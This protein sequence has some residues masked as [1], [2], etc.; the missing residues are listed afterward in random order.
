MRI[1]RLKLV[2]FI[3]IKNGLGKNEI[4]I[5]F[6]NNGNII[7]SLSGKNGS[8]KSTIMSMLSPFKESFDDRKTL[9]LPGKEGIK[10]IDYIHN[11]HEYKIKH[12]YSAKAASFISEDGVEL[13]ENGGI[14]TFEEI[15]KTKFK[16]SKDYFK[17]GKV[18]SNTENFIQFTT[19]QRKTYIS[20]FVEA[21]QKYI[22][23]FKIVS[24]KAK[25][26][27]QQIKQISS[28]LKQLDDISTVLHKIEENETTL[29]ELENSISVLTT[30]IA[31][32]DSDINILSKTMSDINYIETKTLLKTK[33]DS[34]RKNYV[35][36]EKFDKIYN[37]VDI[38]NCD[39]YISEIK[40]ELNK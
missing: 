3:G 2:N 25:V 32:L 24:E 12:I 29:K 26:N 30:D 34:L 20:S 6:P 27:E 16:L 11:G 18:G 33:E 39:Q 8:G 19:A 14:R 5:T 9:I 37:N 31:R 38:S 13:N 35:I 4:E 40:D 23:A 21:V 10:E 7:T 28:D 22:D 17:I 36:N 15:I 1:T